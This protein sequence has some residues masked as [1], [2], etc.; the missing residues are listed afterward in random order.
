MA[1]SSYF[2]SAKAIISNNMLLARIIAIFKI[3]LP[4]SSAEFLKK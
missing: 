4:W 3:D 2:G 1:S